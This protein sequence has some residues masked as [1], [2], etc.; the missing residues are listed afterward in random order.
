[1]PMRIRSA[2]A[3]LESGLDFMACPVS[4]DTAIGQ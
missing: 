4:G 3:C 2:R 1:M